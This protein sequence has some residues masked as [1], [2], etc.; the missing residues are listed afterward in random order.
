MPQWNMY[1]VA[2]YSTVCS[3]KK[4]IPRWRRYTV[5]ASLGWLLSFFHE[6]FLSGSTLWRTHESLV[7]GSFEK[8][9]DIWQGGS[10]FSL[11]GESCFFHGQGVG[12]SFRFVAARSSDESPLVIFGRLRVV[13]ASNLHDWPA[14]Y[15]MSRALS[16][17]RNDRAPVEL[18]RVYWV[19]NKY[20]EIN[21][22]CALECR[23]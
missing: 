4:T 9:S 19:T 2:L 7:F 21:K 23:S 13:R 16:G 20:N 12:V 1:I 3:S 10:V 8:K 5:A 22:G 18:R 17:S 6:L 15:P 14:E 11:M